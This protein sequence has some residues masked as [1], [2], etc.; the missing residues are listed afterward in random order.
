[1]P[2]FNESSDDVPTKIKNRR[3][4]NF[5]TLFRAA[6]GLPVII[7]LE[8]GNLSIA[9]I[10]I[11]LA[12]FSDIADGYLAR[13]AGGGSIWGARLD[14]LADKILLTAPLIWLGVNELIPLWAIWSLISRELIISLWRS[15]NNSGAPASPEGKLKTIL[16]FSSILL[17]LWPSKWGGSNLAFIL[18]RT[19]WYLFWPSLFLAFY[20]A[21]KYFLNQ[22]KTHQN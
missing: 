19:G 15:S 22:P 17:M 16:Q 7:A 6:S 13:K 9:W 21:F 1:M 12:G 2:L 3:L 5:L 10:L 18:E 14:P 8:K 11:L 4:A 20:S